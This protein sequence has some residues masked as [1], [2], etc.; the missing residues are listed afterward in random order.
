MNNKQK[1]INL[2]KDML[3]VTEVN[4]QHLIDVVD[5]IPE[6]EAGGLLLKSIEELISR[7]PE[8]IKKTLDQI[9]KNNIKAGNLQIIK[10]IDGALSKYKKI[11][12]R[13]FSY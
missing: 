7:E 2:I 1:L 9:I 5:R 3:L 13:G 12:L 8:I 6:D 10:V 11:Q 4:R